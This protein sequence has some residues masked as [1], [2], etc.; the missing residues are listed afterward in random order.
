M[1]S[2]SFHLIHRASLF[3]ILYMLKS[4]CVGVRFA[5]ICCCPLW[6]STWCP[7]CEY[8]DPTSHTALACQYALS[9]L[10]HS[11]PIHVP[12]M[13]LHARP[14]C[15]LFCPPPL[16]SLSYRLTVTP[17][18]LRALTDGP[19]SDSICLLPSITSYCPA[20]LLCRALCVCQIFYTTSIAPF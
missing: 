5:C 20:E 12:D 19:R 3:D 8:S 15:P 11:Q 7:V 2:P 1:S 14:L 6:H 18:F 9:H 17:L 16:L 10:A 4:V 13:M